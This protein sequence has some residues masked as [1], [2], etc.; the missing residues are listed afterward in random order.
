MAIILFITTLKNIF[1]L[2]HY[3]NTFLKILL[4]YPYVLSN[5][6]DSNIKKKKEIKNNNSNKQK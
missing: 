3:F 6:I 2:E 1:Y 4:K 5:F